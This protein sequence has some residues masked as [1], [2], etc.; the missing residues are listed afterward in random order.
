[1]KQELESGGQDQITHRGA[2]A[3]LL[4]LLYDSSMLEQILALN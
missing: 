2:A 1:M 3:R 4:H